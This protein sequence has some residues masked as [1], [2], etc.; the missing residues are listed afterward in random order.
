MTMK[1]KFLHFGSFLIKEGSEICH[2]KDSRVGNVNLHYQYPALYIIVRN[3]IDTT[4]EVPETTPPNVTIRWCL[5][6][7]YLA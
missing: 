4:T 2:W 3:K 7:A 1:E 6:G 5:V